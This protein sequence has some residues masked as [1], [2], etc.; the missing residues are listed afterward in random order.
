[1]SWKIFLFL[2]TFALHFCSCKKK[3]K[4]VTTVIDAKWE[5]TSLSLEMSEYLWDENPTVFWKYVDAI[6]NLQPPLIEGSMFLTYWMFYILLI[7]Y[8][9]S[10]LN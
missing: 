4:S 1:M 9:F 10:I 8:F 6:S 5:V 3:A 2:F 7:K